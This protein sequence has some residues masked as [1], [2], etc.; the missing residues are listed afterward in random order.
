M[1][2]ATMDKMIEE[3]QRSDALTEEFGQSSKKVIGLINAGRI[4]L[5]LRGRRETSVQAN[6]KDVRAKMVDV[7]KKGG[8]EVKVPSRQ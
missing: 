2:Y 8:I 1:E 5:R 3:M 4:T 6:L 7:I